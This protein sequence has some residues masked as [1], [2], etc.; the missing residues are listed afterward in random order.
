MS[1]GTG[2]ISRVVKRSEKFLGDY[3]QSEVSDSVRLELAHAYA[4]WWNLSRAEP[5]PP[6]LQRRTNWALMQQN[7]GPSSS[8]R[9]FEST[10]DTGTGRPKQAKGIAGKPEGLKKV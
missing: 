8:I 4:T 10:E 7:R 3:P 5:N 9:I 2:S 6:C 1:R